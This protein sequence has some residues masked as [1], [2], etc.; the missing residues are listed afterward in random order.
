LVKEKLLNQNNPAAKKNLKKNPQLPDE[1]LTI[2][3]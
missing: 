3:H 1:I 2:T